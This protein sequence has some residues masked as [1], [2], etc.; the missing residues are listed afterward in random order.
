VN[1]Y[2]LSTTAVAIIIVVCVVIFLFLARRVL[3]FAIKAALA[4]TLLFALL[5]TAAVGW[6]R[7]WF[8][9]QPPQNAATQSNQRTNSN[10]RTER[11]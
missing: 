2:V 5:L 1:G 8:G 9:S 11:H 6:W 3:R 10:R 4:V 7:G